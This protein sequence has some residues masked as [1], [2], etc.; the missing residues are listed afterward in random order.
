MAS[1]VTDLPDLLKGI[2]PGA[3]VAIS[4]RQNKAIAFGLDAQAVQAEAQR[5][6]EEQPLMVRVPEQTLAMFL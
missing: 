1:T 2:P 3:W 5:K 6:G 4:E